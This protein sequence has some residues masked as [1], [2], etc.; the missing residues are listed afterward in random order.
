MK[1]L[2]K[3][4]IGLF[5]ALGTSILLVTLYYFVESIFLP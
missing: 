2:E 5:L 1:K 4:F 3:L